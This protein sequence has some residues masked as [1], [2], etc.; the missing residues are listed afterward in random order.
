MAN[1]HKL[2]KLNLKLKIKK[3]NKKDKSTYKLL[4]FKLKI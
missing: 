1:A 4:K 3:I 2:L